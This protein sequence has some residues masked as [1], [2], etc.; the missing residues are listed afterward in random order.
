MQ[1]GE[2]NVIYNKTITDQSD[3]QASIIKLA[4]KQL[5]ECKE[6]FK[7]PLNFNSEEFRIVANGFFQARRSRTYI[8]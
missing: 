8:M 4:R 1:F 5:K 2:I 7:L 3:D 6:K